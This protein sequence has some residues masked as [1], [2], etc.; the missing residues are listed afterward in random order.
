VKNYKFEHLKYFFYQEY[1]KLEIYKM[2][3]KGNL[4][5]KMQKDVEARKKE[6]SEII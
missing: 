3:P 1:N 6:I 4:P 5:Y 2:K